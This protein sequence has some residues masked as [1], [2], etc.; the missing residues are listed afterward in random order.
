MSKNVASRF[1]ES[2]VV[3]QH[4]WSQGLRNA[5][6]IAKI[7]KINYGTVKQT[8]RKIKKIGSAASLPRTGRPP[9]ITLETELD[10]DLILS[11]KT[12]TNSEE[13]KGVLESLHSMHFSKSTIQRALKKQGYMYRLPT[14]VPNLKKRHIDA[15]LV[16]AQNA[17]K[18]DW[19][20]V[21]FSDECSIQLYRNSLKIWQDPTRPKEKIFLKFNKKI[22]IWT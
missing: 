10:I 16:W 3:I 19:K 8:L 20:S 21:V 13:V 1:S 7:S 15:R 4:Y 9:K 5:Y 18:T 11:S 6:Q 14:P 17:L 22:M 12:I 2:E